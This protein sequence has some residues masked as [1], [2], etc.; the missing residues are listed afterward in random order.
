MLHIQ[1]FHC[2]PLQENAY[3]LWDETREGVVVDPG[4]DGEA[5]L[6]RFRKFLKENDIRLKEIWLTHGHFDH[7]LGVAALA[8]GPTTGDADGSTADLTEGGTAGSAAGIADGSTT[9][10]TT[11]DAD[12]SAVAGGCN[13][14]IPVRLHPADRPLLERARLMA[15]AFGIDFPNSPMSGGAASPM[16]MSGSPAPASPAR[17]TPFATAD[18]ADGE[19]LH[20]GGTA[21]RVIATPG[22]TPGG[23]S[24]YSDTERIL[25]TGDTL[26]A[27]SIGRT[28]LPGGEYDDLI[29]SIMD[30]LMG[31]DGD[32]EILPGHG[33]VSDIATER[34]H[35]PF[36]QP[37][38]E[39]DDPD[40][41]VDLS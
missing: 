36:L 15:A 31:L 21:F 34:T 40:L 9:A 16:S 6:S 38:N 30:K 25:L 22:H 35:N 11:G 13:A 29:V 33:G 39:P 28:D 5:E 23:V 27:G 18:L 20:V 41:S 8:Q 4:F 32:V 17:E 2:N 3:L 37:F 26:F 14:A 7:V 24:Y 1:V 12:G 19:E 10:S